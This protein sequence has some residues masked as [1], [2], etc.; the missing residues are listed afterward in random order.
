MVP[1]AVY[2]ASP[3]GEMN[4]SYP[5][6]IAVSLNYRD[7]QG[8]KSFVDSV[9]NPTSGNYRQFLSP[10]DVGKRFGPLPATVSRVTSFLKS[11]G[12]SVTLVGDNGLSILA[13]AT[14]AQAEAAF[15]TQIVEF[16]P[17]TG[18][19][20]TSG[21]LYSFVK[22]PS[23]PADMQPF[24]VDISGLENFSHPQALGTN[25]VTPNQIQTL[26]NLAPMYSGGSQGQGRTIAISSWD[27]FRLSNVPHE[28]SEFNLPAP[29]KGVG[30]NITVKTLDGGSG[31]GNE[32]GEGDLDIQSILGVAPLCNLIIYDG[33][34]GDLINVLTH[35][36]NDNEA[37]IISESYGWELSESNIAAAHNLHLSMNAQGITYMAASG[38]HGTTLSYYYPDIDPE[39]LTVG[40]TTVSVTS[41]GE[42]VT[43][44][45][46]SG[47]GGGWVPTS[48]S[49][50]VLPS[51]QSGTGVSTN[52]NYR[53]IPDLALDA[54][55][56][57][58]Y[59]VYLNGG[60]YVIGGTSGA[61]PTFAGSLGDSE[62]QLIANGVLVQNQAGNYRL[63]RLQDVV[64]SLNGLSSVFYDVTSGSNGKLPSGATSEAGVGWDFVT[65]WGAMNFDGFVS[66]L[67]GTGLT[68][69]SVSPSSVEG[70]TTT[71]IGTVAIA[72]P[73]PSGGSAVTISGGDSSISYPSTVTI[74]AG[75]RTA[76]FS[77]TTSAVSSSHTES[78]TAT[79]GNAT[80]TAT[81]TVNPTSITSLTLSPTSL[82]GA[83]TVTGTVKLL[84]A[85]PT[86]GD[87][88]TLSGGDSSISYPSSVTVNGGATS[89]TF[90]VTASMVAATDTES[91]TAT[92][93]SSA[94]SATL[95]LDALKI[96]SL[97]FSPSSVVG[98][99]AS[100]GTVTLS[101]AVSSPTVVTLSGGDSS[102]GLPA[103]VTVAA[104]AASATFRVTTS[105]VSSTDAES[106]TATLGSSTKSA[107]LTVQ[108]IAPSK[109]AFSPSS[110]VGGASS[111][112]TVTLN[113][114]APTGGL[115][116][117][118]SGGDSSV[119]YPSSVTV[120][121]GTA[122]ATFTVTTSSVTSN[123]AETLTAGAN[124]N[125]ASATLTVDAPVV[126]SVAFSPTSVTGGSSSTGTITLSGA[127]PSGGSTVSLSGGNSAV[128]Y[129]ST[130]KVNAGATTAT[131]TITTSSV[132]A[133]VAETI[134]GRI[135]SGT[136]AAG[137]L[138]VMKAS[139]T[140]IGA[141][142]SSVA[143]GDTVTVT[144]T[145]SGPA[146]SS[147]AVV[148]L[149]GGSS[150]VS[151]PTSVT[152]ASGATSATFTLTAKTVQSTS[153]VTINAS[154]GGVVKSLKISV[155]G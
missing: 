71:V 144:V 152:V 45:G 127:A 58:G 108:P 154:Y 66:A 18:Y 113:A 78:L 74:L 130:V 155:T 28:Y 106:I 121:A 49:F 92:L 135:G 3:L 79:L 105:A 14:V 24:V 141:A 36:C 13:D 54:D 98:G 57:S 120:K 46:W 111:T 30:T 8:I 77:I 40:G 93:G 122:T 29:S 73:A 142:S 56:N 11:Q 22:T 103:S 31:A 117:T 1:S 32:V 42:R 138:T 51:W 41:S 116:V 5:L 53:L 37:D 88:V 119:S 136:G 86:G 81:L 128:S 67:T 149:S 96:N 97:A 124:G 12:M 146:G 134:T 87:T 61:S 115:H 112:G 6:H 99:A 17:M 104:K 151:F 140:N 10:A 132:T 15:Q 94:K 39:V 20:P 47:S 83:G 80:K 64:Y 131:F 4:S 16:A 82:L 147:G 55:P 2:K 25:Y 89:A 91:I 63:G 110:V 35:E 114:A 7:P 153:T 125:S 65:G 21:H 107:T 90:T 70:G 62:Q 60:F 27:G 118:L 9:S 85:A 50:N 95:T 19:S 38:D 68:Q 137:A 26:Y 48:D 150:A 34:D 148:A 101:A 84:H 100:T 143:S 33:A 126:K 109:L 69:F 102:I 23:I 133:N 145:L 59:V 76:S 43:E 52:V 129:P 72:T 139:L 123:D 44:V 75:Q